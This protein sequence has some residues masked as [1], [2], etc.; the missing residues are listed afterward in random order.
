MPYGDPDPHGGVHELIEIEKLQKEAHR[1]QA[2]Y[3]QRWLD[4]YERRHDDR[5]FDY[6]RS[7]RGQ[8]GDGWRPSEEGRPIPTMPSPE[9]VAFQ[10]L[11]DDIYLLEKELHQARG[12]VVDQTR[13]ENK[14]TTDKAKLVAALMNAKDVVALVKRL[15]E[16]LGG[17]HD[18]ELTWILQA[19]TVSVSKFETSDIPDEDSTYD[20]ILRIMKIADESG[21]LS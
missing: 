20:V 14:L 3:A 10:K 5:P 17:D 21:D 15:L 12:T 6:W 9:E 19:L 1:E 16:S 4:D 8:G 2:E 18:N 11:R 7:G 13:R